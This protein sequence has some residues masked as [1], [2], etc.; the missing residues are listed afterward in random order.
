MEYQ[1]WIIPIIIWEV[2]WKGIALWYSAKQHKKI[3]FVFILIVNSIGILPII[4][5]IINRKEIK[6]LK[7]K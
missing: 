6:K 7:N 3:W 1:L 5:L 4:Y 2:I